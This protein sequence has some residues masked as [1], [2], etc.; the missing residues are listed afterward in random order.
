M[1]GYKE[2][3]KFDALLTTLV[4]KHSIRPGNAKEWL[5][6]TRTVVTGLEVLEKAALR[7]LGVEVISN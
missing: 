6:F 1:E 3:E 5:S 7:A 4:K 2:A